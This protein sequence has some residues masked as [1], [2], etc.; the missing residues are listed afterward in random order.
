MELAPQHWSY[1]FPWRE[2]LQSEADDPTLAGSRSRGSGSLSPVAGSHG[3]VAMGSCTGGTSGTSGL[4]LGERRGCGGSA[5]APAVW[6]GAAGAGQLMPRGGSF[7]RQ[8]AVPDANGCAALVLAGHRSR[9]CAGAAWL[10]EGA[11][12][13]R[14]EKEENSSFYAGGR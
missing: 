5:A 13:D 2:Q 12:A 1:S 10:K 7:S 8:R 4:S 3:H 11:L 9:R 6:A 14:R